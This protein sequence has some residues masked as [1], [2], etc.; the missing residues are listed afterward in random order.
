MIWGALQ[1]AAL[2]TQERNAAVE[3]SQCSTIQPTQLA[4][5]TSFDCVT[6][7]FHWA[8][9]LIVLGLLTTAL[10]HA[11]SH[12]D[13]TKA[14][15]LRIHRSLGVS[16]WTATAFRLL[17]RM[18]NA[19]LPPF[20]DEMTDIRR[21]L[22]KITEYCLYALLIVQPLTGFVATIARGRSFLL[23]WWHV[24]PLMPHSPTLRAV[25][26]STHRIGAWT[27]GILIMGHAVAALIHYFV[28]RDNVLQRMAPVIGSQR[29]V[30]KLSLGTR[31]SQAS[32]GR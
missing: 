31:D 25:L 9:V 15:M 19:K 32:F 24:P 2:S 27:F 16:V 21:V 23:F 20:P 13:M 3:T 30:R 26:L 5:R 7:A 18:T 17:W 1:M 14:L 12:D 22:V 28:L 6:I 29:S 10:W 8:T 4:K 11:Q